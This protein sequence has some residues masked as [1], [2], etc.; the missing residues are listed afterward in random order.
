MLQN[1]IPNR[2]LNGEELMEIAVQQFRQML[3]NDYAFSKQI[4]YPRVAMTLRATF[5]L[6]EPHPVR[7]IVSYTRASGSVE[8]EVPLNP[9]PEEGTLISLERDVKLDNPNLARVHHDIPIKIVD[10][11]EPEVITNPN[12]LPGE[13]M[14]TTNPFPS[15]ETRELRYDKEQ[16]P[17]MEP[18]P[19]DRDVS[20]QK[21]GELGVKPRGRLTEKERRR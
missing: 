5:H 15:F 18:A 13:L 9:E 1:Q 16:Y 19:V 11:K 21:A 10:R 2:A 7:E 12:P 3:Q 17:P 8:G 20:E 14:Q 4:A 6:G